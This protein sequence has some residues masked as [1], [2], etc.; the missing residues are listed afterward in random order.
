MFLKTFESTDEPEVRFLS[1]FSVVVFFT[2]LMTSVF[3]F[4]GPRSASEITFY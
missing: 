4:D 1:A 3:H 2:F